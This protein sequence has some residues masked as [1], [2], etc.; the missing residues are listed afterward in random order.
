[1]PAIG[2]DLQGRLRVVCGAANVVTDPHELAIY[3]TGPGP[4]AGS[5]PLAV[6]L[7]AN[8]TE[9]ASCV[10]ACAAAGVPWRPR[11][12]NTW[13]HSGAERGIGTRAGTDGETVTI[14]LTRMRHVLAVDQAAGIVSAE[15]GVPGRLLAH[16]LARVGPLAPA[17]AVATLGGLLAGPHVGPRVLAER[18]LRVLALTL[19]LPDGELAELRAGGPGYDLLGR[20]LGSAGAFGVAV[21]AT[22]VVGAPV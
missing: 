14:A 22:I 5:S 6:A 8:M 13:Q 7:P 21:D 9:V 3:R 2:S 20:F 18:R 4:R 16:A 10:A 17:D 12:A 11:G 15:A 1:M 19:V